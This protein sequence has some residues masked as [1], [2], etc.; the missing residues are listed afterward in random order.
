MLEVCGTKPGPE[1]ARME[2]LRDTKEIEE[3]VGKN[4]TT[5]YLKLKELGIKSKL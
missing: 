4:E 2:V 5:Y 1:R 3:D